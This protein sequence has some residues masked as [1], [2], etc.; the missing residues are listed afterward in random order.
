M[1]E[2]CEEDRRVRE[3]DAACVME[4]EEA[5]WAADTWATRKATKK[6]KQKAWESD[7]EDSLPQKKKARVAPMRW[8][9][10]WHQQERPMR[11]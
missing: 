4:A 2:Q 1:Q 9:L 10:W 6:A 3:E 11:V 7:S 5:A 8:E